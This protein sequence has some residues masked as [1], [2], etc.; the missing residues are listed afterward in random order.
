MRS[1]RV[2]L[3]PRVQQAPRRG[4]WMQGYLCVVEIWGG[5]QAPACMVAPPVGTT[6]LPNTCQPAECQAQPT[7]AWVCQREGREAA[8]GVGGSREGT[9][10]EQRWS[11]GSAGCPGN[12]ISRGASL[13]KFHARF[14]PRVCWVGWGCVTREPVCMHR[15]VHVCMCGVQM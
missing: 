13:G 10:G 4:R 8:R 5:P 14:L 7:G 6:A 2:R 15:R 12:G 3:P 11:P 1:G 9:V